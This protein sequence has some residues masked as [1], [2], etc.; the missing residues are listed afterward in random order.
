MN[1]PI[2][3]CSAF[4]PHTPHLTGN[5]VSAAISQPMNPDGS[6]RCISKVVS[7]GGIEPPTFRPN[8]PSL[9]PRHNAT[10]RSD[11]GGVGQ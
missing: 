11:R 7:D 8:R 10:H 6:G 1:T 5:Y 2:T 9:L 3:E 4:E